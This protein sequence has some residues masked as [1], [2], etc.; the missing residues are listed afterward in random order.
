M[1]M[2]ST[3]DQQLDELLQVSIDSLDISD[4]EYR[5]SVSRYEAVSQSLADYWDESPAGG[6]VYPQG[7]MRLGT[8]TRNIHRNDEI[9]IDLVARRDLR[10]TSITQAELKADTGHGL[11]LFVES[12]P[13]GHPSN[14]E[15]K[16]CWTLHYS[17]FHL[18][19]LPALPDEEDSG[20]GILITDTGLR[21]W[22]P[23]NPIGYADWFHAVMRTEWLE[24]RAVLVEKGM[25]VA[26]VPDWKVKTTLQRTVQ[27]LKRHRDIY[28]TDDLADRPA[29]VIITTLAARAYRSGGSLY[30]VLIDVTTAMPT[31]VEK[32]NGVYVVSN[33]VQQKENFADRW[34]DHPHRAQRFFEWVEQART[35]FAGIGSDVGV[36]SALEKMAGAF[37]D[38]A[39]ERA[40]R[41]AGTHLFEARRSGQLAMAAGTGALATGGRRTVRPHAFHGDPA[42]P[43]MIE[44]AEPLRRARERAGLSQDAAADALHINR[45]LLSYYENG[46]RTVPLPTAAA[47]ARLYGTSLDRLLSGDEAMAAAGIDVSGVLYRAAPSV[48]ADPARG[49]LRLFE[50]YLRDYV[51][52]AEE[53][54]RPLPG[55]GQSPFPPVSGSSARDAAD[56]ARQLRRYFNLGGGPVGDPFRVADEYV[57]IWRLPLGEDLDS[58]P[59]GLFYNH[60]QVGFSIVVNSNMTLGRQVFTVAHELA[61]AFFH[62]RS[63]DVIVSMHGAELGRERFADAFAGEFLVPGDELRRLVT[64]HSPW[65]G[66]TNPTTVVHLQRHFGVSYATIRVRLLQERLIDRDTFE[67]LAQVSPS[68]LAQALGYPV[69]PADMGD[70]ARHPLDRFPGRMLLLVRTALEEG[71]ITQGD[72]AETLG[73]S[74]DEIRQLLARPPIGPDE[75]HIQRDLEEAAFAHRTGQGPAS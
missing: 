38:R 48:L 43:P 4:E 63:A 41:A 13:E 62:S 3:L 16:R 53:L 30:D 54:G 57:L 35:D 14:K 46:R 64:E 20:T 52:L 18:D 8:V 7:S 28:F 5:L 58:A 27:A 66:L 47:L 24:K 17:G 26:D 61:H 45:V 73:T 23:S 40:A 60:P 39:A 22:L 2:Y 1:L 9:D 68:R 55:K 69:D 15:G 29:S 19:V 71:V 10:K 56:A 50:Q 6:D 12:R 11:D 34:K 67:A 33:P 44:L 51:E 36:D 72:A 25:D 37:G 49:A 59:S 74:T 75:Q 21:P 32:H 65:D 70:F 42:P 31:F